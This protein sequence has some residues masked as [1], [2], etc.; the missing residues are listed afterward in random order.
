[1][2]TI[3]QQNNDGSARMM[4]FLRRSISLKDSRFKALGVVLKTMTLV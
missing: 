1:M 4:K 3:H 2:S